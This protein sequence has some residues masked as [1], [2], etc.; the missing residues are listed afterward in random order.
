MPNARAVEVAPRRLTFCNA[1]SSA[2]PTITRRANKR[3]LAN[4]TYRLYLLVVGSREVLTKLAAAGWVVVRTKGSHDVRPGTVTV[5]HPRKDLPTGTIKS[6]E[7][8]SGVKLL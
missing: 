1:C 5:P 4:T 8:Q 7:K 6:I 2:P 3:S